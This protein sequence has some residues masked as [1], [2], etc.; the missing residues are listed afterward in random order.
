M[1]EPRYDESHLET[2]ARRSP[3]AHEQCARV[4]WSTPRSCYQARYR[5]GEDEPYEVCCC[6]RCH[7]FGEGDDSE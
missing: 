4:A 5:P 3:Q 7:D 2:L 1:S 6:C